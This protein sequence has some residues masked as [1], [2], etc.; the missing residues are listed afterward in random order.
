M[1]G[2]PPLTFAGADVALEARM[3]DGRVVVRM[4]DFRGAPTPFTQ[5][6]HAHE[7]RGIGWSLAEIKNRIAALPLQGAAPIA[8]TEAL[9][10]QPRGFLH[11][12][13]T[14]AED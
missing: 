12:H 13:H 9:A 11:A 1:T 7:L 8:P 3:P 2:R 14:A 5:P 6:A 4:V 10:P